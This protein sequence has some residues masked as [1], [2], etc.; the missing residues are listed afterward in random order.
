MVKSKIRLSVDL[1]LKFLEKHNYAL[2]SVYCQN[3]HIYFAECRTP[4]QQK[5]FI[6][7]I[8]D[9]YSLIL[10]ESSPDIQA[11]PIKRDLE[12]LKTRQ[13][14]YLSDLRG[15]LLS[16]DLVAISGST[17]CVH[18]YNETSELYNLR[19]EEPDGE[20][21]DEESESESEDIVSELETETTEILDKVDPGSQLPKPKIPKSS[22]KTSESKETETSEPEE[23][24]KEE[25][26]KR[27]KKK[28]EETSKEEPEAKVELIFED[29]EGGSVEDVQEFIEPDELA[30]NLHDVKEDLE[31]EG[32]P[33]EET[34][35]VEYTTHSN[36]LPP[37]MEYSDIVLGMVYPMVSLGDF[38]KKVKTYEKEVISI[39][40]QINDNIL[41]IR[42]VK[43][44]EIK[45]LSASFL[46]HAEAKL[47]DID[48]KEKEL[49]TSLVR[50]TIILSQVDVLK[51]RVLANKKL[52]D[53]IERVEKIQSQT[54]QT[55]NELNLDLLRLQDS[56]DE[57]LS[58]YQASIKGLMEL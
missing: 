43:L 12:G 32:L 38:Y 7:H 51:K 36:D 53:E 2:T 18:K 27:S 39:C 50:L 11:I 1:F 45:T 56:A 44:Q 55:I 52:K 20:G 5:T 41:D 8:P 29:S 33:T 16:C 42:K 46:A 40:E 37:D 4:R 17:L 21:E 57:L 34:E 47:A 25:P 49:R 35:E 24:S 10:G 26:N 54:R 6:I 30:K 28:S 23:T 14:K 15:S 3:K 31:S 19:D 58:N 48:K 9:R 13:I 22:A